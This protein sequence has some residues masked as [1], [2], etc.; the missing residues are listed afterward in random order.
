MSSHTK[1]CACS[2]PPKETFPA[3]ADTSPLADSPASRP[4]RYMHRRSLSLAQCTTARPRPQAK[5]QPRSPPHGP[6]QVLV[7]E[8]PYTF[9]PTK[10]LFTQRQ[11]THSAI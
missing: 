6:V 3:C 8:P 7:V 4:P 2:P 10:D 5:A 9:P 1:R 11:D